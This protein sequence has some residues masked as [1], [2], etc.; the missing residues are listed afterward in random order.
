MVLL[1]ATDMNACSYADAVQTHTTTY[2]DEDVNL[3]QRRDE[4][5]TTQEVVTKAI[6][7][8]DHDL[9]CSCPVVA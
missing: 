1:D 4:A 9:S 6:A 2:Y 3:Q 8:I 7:E 5:L